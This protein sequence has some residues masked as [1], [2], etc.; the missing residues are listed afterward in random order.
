MGDK[1]VENPALSE[2]K[3]WCVC[4]LCRLILYNIFAGVTDRGS[5]NSRSERQH[6]NIS[7]VQEDIDMTLHP[8]GQYIWCNGTEIL[9]IGP[10]INP[11]QPGLFLYPPQPGGSDPTPRAI[12]KTDGHRDGR[13]GIRKISTKRFQSTFEKLKLK[14]RHL[15]LTCLVKVRSKAKIECIQVVDRRDLKRSFFAQN[16]PFVFPRTRWRYWLVKL[17]HI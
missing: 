1:V 16:F 3:T 9:H 5:E 15:T 14:K 8:E 7:E 11:P 6:V 10:P 13:G 17:F 12:S 4:N 2:K